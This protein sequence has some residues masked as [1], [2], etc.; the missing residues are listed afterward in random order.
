VTFVDLVEHEDRI[1]PAGLFGGLHDAAGDRADVGPAVPADFGFVAHAA[2]RDA[3][4]PAIHRAR[5]RLAERRLAHAR[6]AD[7]A[8]N[9]APHLRRRALPRLQLPH[10]QVLDD[11]ILDLV[12][13]MIQSSGS[14]VS[15]A[16]GGRAGR[17][18]RVR[19]VGFLPYPTC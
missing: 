18:G 13:S 2:E 12:E 16:P 6:W 5:D 7:E 9:R 3:D 4:E 17:V 10:R 1:H 19:R 15:H 11:A 8:E 14:H